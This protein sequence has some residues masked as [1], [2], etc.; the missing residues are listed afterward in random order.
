MFKT[1]LSTLHLIE[2]ILLYTL[3]SRAVSITL[4]ATVISGHCNGIDH[5]S[6]NS[7]QKAYR[8]QIEV[9]KNFKS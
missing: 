1:R 7:Y 4:M 8:E 3:P 2:C 9:Q 5:L 6:I